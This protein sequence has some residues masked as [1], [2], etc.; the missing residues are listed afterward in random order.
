MSEEAVPAYPATFE[1]DPPGKIARWRIIG[2]IILAIPQLII[3]SVLGRVAEVLA[4]VG[5][6]LGIFTGK[7]PEGIL[8]FIA[9]YIRYNTRVSTYALFLKEEYP[10][11][12]FDTTFADPGNDPRV[13]VDLVP[14]LEG[15]NR[16]TIFFRGLLIIPH[17][18]ALFFVVIAFLFVLII[19]WFAVLF[20][21]TWPT[22]LRDFA[23]GLQ[24]WT[25]RLS[26]YGYLLTDKYPPFGFK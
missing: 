15:R 2:N 12:E 16:L 25:V 11:F 10:P 13:R 5:W 14:E 17:L 1:F 3:S 26:A 22:G 4:I 8:K 18:I 6:V 19:A 20:T 7:I 24:R 23:I 21:G 9:L